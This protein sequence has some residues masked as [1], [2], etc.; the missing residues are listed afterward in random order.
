[1][2]DPAL[3]TV[4][5]RAAAKINLH[6]GVGAPGPDG[7]HPLATVYQAISLFSTITAT[8]ADAWS[9]TCQ[10]APGIAV[11]Q[12]PLDETKLALSA[13][14]LLARRPGMTPP[15]SP[16]LAKRIPVGAR[17]AGGAADPAATMGHC[18]A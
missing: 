10:A 9:V 15:S 3:R 4:S 11:D 14:T 18:G 1:M 16:H 5:A 8:S 6:L 7:F 2:P 17:L 13:A 12:V